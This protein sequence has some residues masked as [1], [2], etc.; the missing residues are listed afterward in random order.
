MQ[1]INEYTPL[2]GSVQKPQLWVRLVVGARSHTL[3]SAASSSCALLSPHSE[4]L[5]TLI[6]VLFG[7][8]TAAHLGATDFGAPSP[9]AALAHGGAFQHAAL[10]C[11]SSSLLNASKRMLT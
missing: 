6:F 3:I 7:A 10:L 11:A 9:G 5:G 2:P 4:F 8:G 1:D